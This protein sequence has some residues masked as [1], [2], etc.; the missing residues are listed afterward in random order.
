VHI[1]EIHYRLTVIP[2]RDENIYLH[3]FLDKTA[4]ESLSSPHITLQISSLPNIPGGEH[5]DCVFGNTF[6]STAIIIQG[7][8]Q[9]QVPKGQRFNTF[10]TEEQRDEVRLDIKFAGTT[11][12]TTHIPLL[13]CGK[14][15]SCHRYEMVLNNNK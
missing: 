14:E 13:N 3:L 8:L 2:I 10:V 6:E 1:I 15:D 12:L 7:G 4:T 11:L 9:C 5:F